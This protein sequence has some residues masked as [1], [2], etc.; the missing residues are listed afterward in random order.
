MAAEDELRCGWYENPRPKTHFLTD[1]D[2]EWTI[3]SPGLE[4]KGFADLPRA[5]FD[6]GSAW[7][8]VNGAYGYG[9]ACIQGEFGPV[10]SGRILEVHELKPLPLS[11]CA[12]DPALPEAS[13]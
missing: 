11:R 6:F 9:C 1:A 2:G 10:G 3:A 5:S 7:V 4:A 8:I 12:R 13:G